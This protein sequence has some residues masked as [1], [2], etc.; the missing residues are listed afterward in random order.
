MLAFSTKKLQACCLKN[1]QLG[2]KSVLLRLKPLGS[3]SEVMVV[4]IWPSKT[5]LVIDSLVESFT[6]AE[7]PLSIW[8]PAGCCSPKTQNKISKHHPETGQGPELKKSQ[9]PD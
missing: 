5:F 8:K 7:I 2:Q 9:N 6:A 4:S 3:F 1:P